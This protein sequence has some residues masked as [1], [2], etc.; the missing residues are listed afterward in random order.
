MKWKLLKSKDQH[1][2]FCLNFQSTS[3]SFQD[4]SNQNF[5]LQAFTVT[6]GNK[7]VKLSTKTQLFFCFRV[8]NDA[9]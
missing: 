4:A 1:I 2:N 9:A 5:F 7:L 6:N 8:A 3:E